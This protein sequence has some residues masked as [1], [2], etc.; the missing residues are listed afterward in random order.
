MIAL[1]RIHRLVLSALFST[2]IFVLALRA[3]SSITLT[4]DATEAPR[5]IL[6]IA[7]SMTIHA[8]QTTLY[9]P[10]WIPGEHGPTGP[11]LDLVSLK[12]MAGG[13]ALSWR[14]D[15]VDMYAIH[16]DV[17]VETYSLDLAFDFVLP[18]ATEGFSSGAS[19]SA[20]L[21]VLSWNQVVLYPEDQNPDSITVT[22]SLR[23]PDAWKFGTALENDHQSEGTIH[24]KPISLTILIDSPVL[25]GAHFK[26]I[27]ITAGTTVPVFL[28]IASDGD[29]ALAMSP[30]Q[31]AK[32][33]NLVRE[34]NALF[35]AH[36]YKH[37]DFLYT[38]SDQVAHFGLEHHQSSDDRVEER[39]LLNEDL[40][41]VHSGLLP[42]EYV[43]SWNGK[44]R[45][46]A[47]LATG[48]YSTPMKGDLLWVYEGLTQ[49]LGN[50]LAARSGLRT[51]DEYRDHLAI[52]AAALDNRPGREWRP[53]QDA[54][55]EAQL[56]YYG[57][58]DWGSLRRSVDFYDEGDL[59]WLEVDASIRQITRGKR[60]LDDFCKR[61]HGGQSSGPMV[62]IYT[63]EDIVATLNDV[64]KYDWATFLTDRLQSLNAHAPLGGIEKGGWK[65]V[66]RDMPNSMQKAWESTHKRIDM[67]FSLGILF[68]EEGTMRDVVPG[69]PAAKAGLAPGMK[70]VAID[71]RKY[72]KDYLRDAVRTGKN[73]TNPM[74]FLVVNGDYYST[75]LIN[76]HDGERYPFLERNSSRPDVLST[77]ISPVAARIRG[78]HER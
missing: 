45:R 34:A 21:L 2:L 55:D 62:K 70:L 60:S 14:R 39:T 13:N 40:W 28:D 5:K 33:Q 8:G 22:P 44:Y 46:P 48:D 47:D 36:H 12:I 17:P 61:F 10:K 51:P 49:Y 37:Y 6:H 25:A 63:F 20:S 29:A 7:E 18:A 19:S 50:L 38:L 75:F 43:H 65:L 53:L 11:V 73:S 31:I 78:R 23:L 4:V 30:E 35:G 24:F 52:V 41:K 9:Y 56:L 57:R 1:G 76:Y 77:I 26:R 3:Q 69:T 59:V 16:C 72:S 67:S 42:H 54:A 58:D 66:Y 74:Q 64:A 71:G 32:H 68:D 15:L 27:D